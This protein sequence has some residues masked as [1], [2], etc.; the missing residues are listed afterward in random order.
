VAVERVSVAPRTLSLGV[1]ET[2]IVT[3]TVLPENADNRNVLWSS[4]APGVATVDDEGNVKAVSAGSATLTA[5]TADGGKTAGCAVFVPEPEYS[6]TD[7][8]ADGR[9]TQLQQATE[10]EGIDVVLMGDAYSDRLIADGTYART[11]EFAMESFFTEEPYRSHR[12]MFNV[13]QVD[14]VSENELIAPDSSTALGCAFGD[15]TLVSGRDRVVMNYTPDAVSST[16]RMDN[17]VLIVMVNDP[18]WHGTCYMYTSTQSGGDYG[19]GLSISYFSTGQN[20]GDL[21][22]LL[23]HEANGHGFP[24]LA[25]EYWYDDGASISTKDIAEYRQ[26]SPLGWWKNIDL[27]SD[28]EQVKWSRFLTDLRFAGQGLGVYEGGFVWGRGVWRS[29]ETSIMRYNTGGFNAPS[30]EAI[31]YK[32]NKLA[33]GAEWTYDYETFVAWDMAHRLAGYAARTAGVGVL[34]PVGHTPPVVIRRSW[35][36]AYDIN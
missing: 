16:D 19:G 13:W 11:M 8:S 5:T 29:T 35:R 4:S 21:R 7:Y 20:S 26:L 31:Y 2:A 33:H 12:A 25:D 17:A 9:V 34:K 14:V 23:H 15:G 22:Q 10:G 28:P 27:T 24:K 1:G 6:S 30:R 3:A 36:E 32:I 18:G